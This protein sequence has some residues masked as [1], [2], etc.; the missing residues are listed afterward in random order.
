AHPCSSVAESLRLFRWIG[1]PGGRAMTDYRLSRRSMLRGLGVS[2]ALPWLESLPVWGDEPSG[3]ARASEPPV[4]LAVL[5]A[6]NGCHSTEW[7]ARGEGKD[8]KLG[9]VLQPLDD[10]REKVLL[11]RG[12]YNEEAQKGNIHSSQ[13]GNL[14]SGAPLASGGEI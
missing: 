7:W 11:I 10:L 13:T 5:F 12:L 3:R 6:G 4:R 1:Y 9:K 2:V 14:L 8:L